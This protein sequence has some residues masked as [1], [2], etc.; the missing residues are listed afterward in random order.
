MLGGEL[1]EC[2]VLDDLDHPF[3]CFP[4]FLSYLLRD[5][6]DVDVFLEGAEELGKR[7]PLHVDAD[8]G[9]AWE[10]ESFSRVFLLQAVKDAHLRPD[11]V[12]LSVS[13]LHV[14]EHAGCACYVVGVLQDGR[15]ALWV[16]YKE[17]LR[18]L[19]FRFNYFVFPQ[20][21]FAW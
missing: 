14:V 3:K 8:E 10:D 18:V 16:G 13:L 17:R 20:A 5:G 19:G 7:Y 15:V 9:R 2:N 21:R 6:D 4:G 12:L 1:F 11:Y